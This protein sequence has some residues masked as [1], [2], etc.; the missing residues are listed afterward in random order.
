MVNE[1]HDNALARGPCNY[2]SPTHSVLVSLVNENFL[3]KYV[4][5]NRAVVTPKPTT[6]YNEL[7]P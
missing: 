3:R 6:V 4:V 5:G 7:D 2:N 1:A